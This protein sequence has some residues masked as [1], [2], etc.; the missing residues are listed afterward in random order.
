[1][2]TVI[3]P[4]H[5]PKCS[6]HLCQC[7]QTLVTI[8]GMDHGAELSCQQQCSHIQSP[9]NYKWGKISLDHILFTLCALLCYC[10]MLQTC[11]PSRADLETQTW[12]GKIWRGSSLSQRCSV[13]RHAPPFSY[14]SSNGHSSF[15]LKASLLDKLLIV[16]AFWS[17]S[18]ILPS[19]SDRIIADTPEIV[20]RSTFHQRIS[21]YFLRIN[22]FIL[23]KDLF[24]GR[25]SK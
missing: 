7:T 12:W 16:N 13:Q 20:E 19:S 2:L 4:E 9:D 18:P 10:C 15:T 3:A 22:V 17:I 1:M 21:K 14:P 11:H 24:P 8:L 6:R 25:E 23:A 5:F